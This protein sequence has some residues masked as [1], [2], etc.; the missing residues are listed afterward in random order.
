MSSP[1]GK[2]RPS[3]ASGTKLLSLA[4]HLHLVYSVPV[5]KQGK[6][7]MMTDGDAFALQ[8]RPV[9]LLLPHY[10]TTNAHQS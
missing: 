3:L 4:H 5:C 8:G 7:E 10:T 1:S 9:P 2:A 6:V